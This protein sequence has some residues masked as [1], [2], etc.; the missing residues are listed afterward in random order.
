MWMWTRAWS[1]GEEITPNQ[2]ALAREFCLADNFYAEVP[3]SDVGHVFLT[4]GHLTEFVNISGK[5]TPSTG[6]IQPF[7]S[8]T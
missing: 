6:P 7:P 8:P 4:A 5:R 1:W 2:H 3:N